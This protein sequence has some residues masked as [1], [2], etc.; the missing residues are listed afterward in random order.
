MDI[1]GIIIRKKFTTS[2]FHLLSW[3]CRVYWPRSSKIDPK[4]Y[5][6]IQKTILIE[7]GLDI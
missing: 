5:S 6:G 2:E 3:R 7:R 1:C 4:T